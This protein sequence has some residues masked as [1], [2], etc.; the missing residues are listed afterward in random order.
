MLCSTGDPHVSGGFTLRCSTATVALAA[1][2]SGPD[3]PAVDLHRHMHV[4]LLRNSHWSS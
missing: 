2:L 4:R 1:T 3:V